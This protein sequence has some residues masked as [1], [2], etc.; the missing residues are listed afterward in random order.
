M[1]KTLSLKTDGRRRRPALSCVSCRK[2]KIRCDRN[3]PC[4]ACVRSKHKTC[5]FEPQGLP[6]LRPSEFQPSASGPPRP[7]DAPPNG[8]TI[9]AA[10]STITSRSTQ[11]QHG[12]GSNEDHSSLSLTGSTP[13]DS[14]S[15]QS[16]G[17]SFDVTSLLD[18][19]REL[20]R[21]LEES[22]AP[23]HVPRAS[24]ADPESIATYPSYLAG[25]LHTMNRSVMT[26][27]RY[28]GQT[29][30][31]NQVKSFKPVLEVFDQQWREKKSEPIA[32][33]GK[34]KSLARTIKAR[35]TPEMS[36]KFGTNIP[37]RETADELVDAYLRTL[38]SIFRI[39]HV[40]SFRK[41][42]EAFWLSSDSPDLPFVIQLQLVMAI[43][44]TLHDDLFTMRSSAMQWV[45]EAQCWLITPIP[46]SRLTITCLQNM[47]LLLLAR[48]TASVGPD[49]IWISV[50]QVMRTAIFM[51]LHRDPKKLPKMNR[52]RSEIRRR[53]WNT[54][55]EI[56]LQSSVD[57]GG[58]PLISLEDFDTCAPTDFDDDQLTEDGNIATISP[59]DKLTDMSLALALRATF[60]ARLAI[61]QSLNEIDSDITYDDTIR[62]HNHLSAAYKST[63]QT[64][65][66]LASG[67][68]KPTAFQRRFVDFIVRR[69]FMTLHL[70]YFVPAI[71]EPAYAFSRK[72][73]VEMAA[74]LYSIVFP[75]AALSPRP[76]RPTTD[77]LGSTIIE[78]DDFARFTTC[79][80]GLL[81]SILSQV[82]MVVGFEIQNQLKED[83]SLGPPSPRQ[84]LLNILHD[85]LAWIYRRIRAGET[86]I[87]GY[88][89]TSVLVAQVDALI[90]GVKGQ[91]M[92]D[93]TIK[94]GTE[95]V[96]ESLEL[97]KQ[98]AR[99]YP[100]E[101][102]ITNDSQF[103]FDTVMAMEE[104][105][106]Y[107][108]SVSS[109][110]P[111]TAEA[112]D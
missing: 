27:T 86:N 65:Q 101:G 26:K 12:E 98:L 70:P 112:V 24:V 40:P 30:W 78:A 22:T 104:D 57:S 18:R 25:D 19:I 88:L 56:A 79:A 105:W 13:V 89:F 6:H 52:F 54:I 62:L 58:P 8:I 23:R 81:R 38:E 59:P 68:R 43:G 92:V 49:L 31:M 46:K 102:A 3:L 63:S 110:A 21:R 16:H 83:D 80:S 44:S 97:L 93:V 100:D 55:L 48:Q 91:D 106:D 45:N 17:P 4:G 15:S 5:V 7:N 10:T 109:P 61:V 14:T 72:T 50:G 34:C 99:Q 95:A 96:R 108:N 87:K 90:N 75:S 94:T 84:D 67:A 60:T 107:E 51:G 28:L 35:R 37:S 82:S 73:V 39:L 32:L 36:F 47:L 20:E 111:E 1:N 11:T 71:T 69:Y 103:S 29:H 76:L 66:R 85:S 77:D 53:L 42:Y 41:E 2:S 9:D 64:L 74:K 33:I